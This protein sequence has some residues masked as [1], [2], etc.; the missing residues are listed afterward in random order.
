ML[1]TFMNFIHKKKENFVFRF[2]HIKLSSWVGNSS[3]SLR[4]LVG[5]N[6]T[7]NHIGTE[8]RSKLLRKAAVRNIGQCTKV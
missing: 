1:N 5:V 7:F 3:P 8:T 6:S 4:F 2:A